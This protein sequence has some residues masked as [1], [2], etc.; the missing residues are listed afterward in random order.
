[1]LRWEWECGMGWIMASLYT[2][3]YLCRPTRQDSTTASTK[4]DTKSHIA[5]NVFGYISK[6]FILHL[7]RAAS[8]ANQLDM[9]IRL[10][11]RYAWCAP[12]A[13]LLLWPGYAQGITYYDD[14]RSWLVFFWF[15]AIMFVARKLR[16]QVAKQTPYILLYVFWH[17]VKLNFLAVNFLNRSPQGYLR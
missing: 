9:R 4:T 2:C 7:R 1:M 15:C 6:S 14:L 3:I 16:I 5:S 8:T 12:P 11:C 10:M 13:T 17:Y